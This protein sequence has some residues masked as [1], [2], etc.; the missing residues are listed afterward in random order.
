MAEVAAVP[1]EYSS[2]THPQQKHGSWAPWGLPGN[3]TRAKPRGFP[4]QVNTENCIEGPG[5]HALPQ[6]ATVQHSQ[7]TSHTQPA[8][9]TQTHLHMHKQPCKHKS[10]HSQRVHTVHVI[11]Y[12]T[13][14]QQ[15]GPDFPI[16]VMRSPGRSSSD[17]QATGTS[18][19]TWVPRH[20]CHKRPLLMPMAA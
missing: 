4:W 20:Y 10:S 19:H 6:Q 15:R 16:V 18:P 17:P 2:V 3:R 14:V 12:A 1:K 13:T 7:S 8:A 11:L 5:C 9:D